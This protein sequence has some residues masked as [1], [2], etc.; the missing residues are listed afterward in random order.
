MAPTLDANPLCNSSCRVCHYKHLD[1]PAQLSRKQS[2]AEGQ[3]RRWREVLQEIDPAPIEERLGYRSKSWMKASL[4]FFESP[5]EGGVSFG[6]FRS[7]KVEGQW[8]KEFISWNT[9]PLHVKSI[10][11]I[12]ERLRENLRGQFKFSAHAFESL[13]GIWLGSPHL[14]IVSRNPDLKEAVQGLDWSRI[15]VAPFDRVW[16]HFNAQVGR[17]VFGH[18]PIELIVG[19]E[20]SVAQ[21]D[22]QPRVHPIRAFRQIAQTLLVRARSQA[23]DALL[24]VKPDLVLD[25]YCGTGDFSLSLPPEVGWLGI[26]LSH[27]AVK[28]ANTLRN[29]KTSVHAAFTGAV[30]QRLR[31]PKVLNLIGQNYALYLNPPRSGLTEEA[32]ERVLALIGEKPPTTIVY[33]SCSVSSLVRDLIGFEKKGYFVKLLKPYDFFPQTEHFETLAI[34]SQF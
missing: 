17:R 8:E 31:D 33:L 15:L 16:F 29:S 20:P 34:L 12:I 18:H 22:L 5:E 4:D 1:Y 13:V 23:L 24:Q 3:L 25:L 11:L 7:I 27:E 28:Y 10:Q 32:S 30:E 14:V 21:Q 19:E 26:E 9:C 2:W 6:M